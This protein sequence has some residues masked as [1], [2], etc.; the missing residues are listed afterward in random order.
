MGIPKELEEAIA[1]IKT[2]RKNKEI[3]RK[4]HAKEKENKIQKIKFTIGN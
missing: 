4:A 3:H 1:C 2:N